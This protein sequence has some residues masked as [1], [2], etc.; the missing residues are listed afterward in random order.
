M[1]ECVVAFG[2][3][4]QACFLKS[5]RVFKQPASPADTDLISDERTGHPG[6]HGRDEHDA[7]VQPTFS[8]QRAR[9]DQ[10][11]IAE[12]R[13][14]APIVMTSRKRT[15]YPSKLM[16]AAQVCSRAPLEDPQGPLP[17]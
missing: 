9:R 16:I 15:M 11:R 4:F 6:D 13:Q 17:A 12:D 10:G 5:S 3:Q 8:S 2:Q 7:Y 1:S 14:A